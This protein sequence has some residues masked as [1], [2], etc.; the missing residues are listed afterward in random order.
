[1][2]AL[3]N[4]SGRPLVNK[5]MKPALIAIPIV[6]GA[7][8][9]LFMQLNS[10]KKTGLPGTVAAKGVV[11]PLTS[12]LLEKTA[13]AVMNNAEDALSTPP[14]QHVFG[15]SRAIE[16][17]YVHDREEMTAD[18]VIK[19][20]ER[21]LLNFDQLKELVSQNDTSLEAVSNPVGKE[22]R[23]KSGLSGYAAELPY[24]ETAKLDLEIKDRVQFEAYAIKISQD[25]AKT[26]AR[27]R[28]TNYSLNG[29]KAR[30]NFRAI[31][32]INNDCMKC[33]Q[34]VPKNMPIG[35]ITLLRLAKE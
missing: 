28:V 31:Y 18:R 35:T 10:H 3:G 34:D 26:G 16:M 22:P 32:P 1:M 20:P 30:V 33:H 2:L 19:F 4:H 8:G 14:R 5:T 27:N 6:A 13:E 17:H 25:M 21:V 23:L 11:L 29:R 24:L 7:A 9:I 12:P 15:M